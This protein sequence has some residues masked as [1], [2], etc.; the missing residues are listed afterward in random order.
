MRM[1]RERAQMAQARLMRLMKQASPYHPPSAC[2]GR[3]QT[4]VPSAS[5]SQRPSTLGT[6]GDEQKKRLKESIM[7]LTM[8][9]LGL[10]K[11]VCV[12]V[13]HIVSRL[14]IDVGDFHDADC[15][16]QVS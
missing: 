1:P 6:T 7:V 15:R 4:P 12:P 9:V 10:Q 16:V 14:S 11:S 13:S 8:V 5:S 3:H 2:R